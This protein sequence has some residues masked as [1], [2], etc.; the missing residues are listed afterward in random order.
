[1]GLKCR[2]R[3]IIHEQIGQDATCIRDGP[4]YRTIEW[5][6]DQIPLVVFNDMMPYLFDDARSGL[7]PPQEWARRVSAKLRTWICG[8]YASSANRDLIFVMVCDVNE[9]VSPLKREEQKKRDVHHDPLVFTEEQM[10][11]MEVHDI[12][13]RVD[14]EDIP[15]PTLRILETR[16][17]RERLFRYLRQ[18]LERDAF[19][20]SID[21]VWCI[22]SENCDCAKRFGVDVIGKHEIGEAEL[23]CLYLYR[24]L[25]NQYHILIRTKDT[26][27]VALCCWH[28]A[29]DRATLSKSPELGFWLERDVYTIALSLF[30]QELVNHRWT[31]EAFF[32]PC[33]LCGGDIVEKKKVC[34][35]VGDSKVFEICQDLLP[36]AGD[37]RRTMSNAKEFG[38]LMVHLRSRKRQSRSSVIDVIDPAVVNIA[39]QNVLSQ[40]LYWISCQDHLTITASMEPPVPKSIAIRSSRPRPVVLDTRTWQREEKKRE[41]A[42]AVVP[43]S[44]PHPG[45][46]PVRAVAHGSPVSRTQ[47]PRAKTSRRRVQ[48]LTAAQVHPD[49]EPDPIGQ[50]LL[51]LPDVPGDF[52]FVFRQHDFSLP[53]KKKKLHS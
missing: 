10:Q 33:L 53:P 26:D 42:R 8:F 32:L 24:L 12:G 18:Q 14:G 4:A 40:Y 50:E 45:P 29:Q 11:A 22:S 30:R 49:P 25:R 9:W 47:V 19:F 1:M 41:Q 15:C 7:V 3:D 28:E 23:R 13:F 6:P 37:V 31:P 46:S 17:L 21:L 16:P 35:G 2:I 52:A 20:K 34:H 48:K 43:R 44:L 39:F 51:T 36:T 27:A 38:I 5:P